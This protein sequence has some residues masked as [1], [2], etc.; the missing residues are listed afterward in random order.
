MRGQA[1][2]GIIL[3]TL[4]LSAL[5]IASA[6]HL[7]APDPAPPECAPDAPDP[8][9]IV[10]D[11]VGTVTGIVGPIV[12]DAQSRIAEA[13]AE[14]EAFVADAQGRATTFASNVVALAQRNADAAIARAT[15]EAEA[16]PAA[17]DERLPDDASEVADAVELRARDTCGRVFAPISP[18]SGADDEVAAAVAALA[19]ASDEAGDRVDHA[20]SQAREPYGL[21]TAQAV[22]LVVALLP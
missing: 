6:D 8:A 11:A 21:C 20:W 14:A 15:A 9:P 16:A 7:C 13:Q 5:P 22:P 12:A 2:V 3:L 4:T 1:T 17:I 19:L 18:L 10:D